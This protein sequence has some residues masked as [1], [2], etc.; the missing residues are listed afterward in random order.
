MARI[1]DLYDA[2]NAYLKFHGANAGEDR[3]LTK[4]IAKRKYFTPIVMDWVLAARKG[5]E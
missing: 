2:D 5:A 3:A 4:E 1:K